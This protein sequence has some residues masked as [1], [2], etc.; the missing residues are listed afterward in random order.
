M[1]GL[2][3]VFNG[4]DA[5]NVAQKKL[6]SNIIETIAFLCSSIAELRDKYRNELMEISQS[7]LNYFQKINDDE[8][9]MPTLI[10]SFT[11]ISLGMKEDFLPILETLLPVFEKYIKADIGFKLEDSA[12]DDYIPEDEDNK[13]LNSII[14][15]VGSNN[16]KLSLNTFA[17]QNKIVCLNALNCIMQN[18][19]TCA[20]KYTTQLIQIS[21]EFLSFPLSGKIRK[22]A[23]KLFNTLIRI[24]S[25][26]KQQKFIIDGLGND[27]L[28]ELEKLLK[29]KNFKDAKRYLK[30]FTFAFESVKEKTNFSE[31]FISKLYALLGEI[32]KLVDET[33]KLTLEEANDGEEDALL[34]EFDDYNEIERRVMEVNGIIFKLFGEPLTGL[35]SQYLLDSFL[36]NWKQNLGR[37]VLN[38]DQEILNS[39]CFFDDFIEFGD[40]V[41]I[42][43]IIASYIEFTSTFNTENEDILQ[44]IV[45]GYGAVSKKLPKAEFAQF[46]PTV[47]S[48]IA[49]IMQREVNEDNDR[50]YDN[51]IGALGKFVAYQCEQDQQ[52]AAMSKQFIKLL[53]LK[54]DLEEGKSICAEFFSYIKSNNPLI[55]SNENIEEIKVTLNAIK[56]LNAE[57]SFLDE[58]ENNL[59]EIM[60]KFGI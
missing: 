40:L 21:K 33:K 25:D 19:G 30:I 28:N 43:M 59:K 46:K 50:T 8:I 3:K 58:E 54:H 10:N 9:Q 29:K 18:V 23:A 52:S 16:T 49:K 4:L 53:P 5:K 22:H 56:E 6:K 15:K 45:F 48:F 13:D 51:A 32:C 36:T 26:N 60:D 14:L 47:I 1:P 31:N 37:K 55:M 38:S 17:L 24:N 20:N 42:K 2:K 12:L 34:E 44:S 7:F 39:I 57:K 35:V 27:L 41:A 11:H